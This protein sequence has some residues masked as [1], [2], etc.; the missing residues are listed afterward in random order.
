MGVGEGAPSV[1][2]RG[3]GP[4][5]PPSAAFPSAPSLLPSP[6]ELGRWPT[7]P[8]PPSRPGPAPCPR[9]TYPPFP[10]AGRALL[11]SFNLC[12]CLEGFSLLSPLTSRSSCLHNLSPL[13]CPPLLPPAFLPT[14]S[15][16]NCAQKPLS[17]SCGFFTCHHALSPVSVLPNPLL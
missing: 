14:S 4:G 11:P 16:L 12:P 7:L 3:R 9:H 1:D 15:P 6:P 17:A 2:P 13:S 5:S 10:A 8:G